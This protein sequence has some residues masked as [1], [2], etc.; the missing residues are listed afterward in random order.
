MS[1]GRADR[2]GLRAGA[3]EISISTEG[4]E[5]RAGE[6]QE[7]GPRLKPTLIRDGSFVGLKPHA[8]PEGL[9]QQPR[10]L[11]LFQVVHEEFRLG[12]QIHGAV[13]VA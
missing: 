11:F 8:N 12:R 2:G 13:G 10:H 4:A 3:G 7:E 1:L 5:K 6:S 9:F